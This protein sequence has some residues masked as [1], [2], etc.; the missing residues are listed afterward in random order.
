MH[1]LWMINEALHAKKVTFDTDFSVLAHKVLIDVDSSFQLVFF[2]W[3]ADVNFS[4]PEM[5]T[6][7]TWQGMY[8][9]FCEM[10]GKQTFFQL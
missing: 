5:K 3:S 8:I 9:I 1:I 7:A 4:P 6:L 2:S 10:T